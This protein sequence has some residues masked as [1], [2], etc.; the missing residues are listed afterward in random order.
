MELTIN[1]ITNLRV[2]LARASFS[3]LEEA[4]IGV[5]LDNKLAAV[6]QESARGDDIPAGD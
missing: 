5:D 6:F 1:D 4:R 3:G 2:I